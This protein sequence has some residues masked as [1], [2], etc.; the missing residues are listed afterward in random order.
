M[1]KYVLVLLLF[2][3]ALNASSQTGTITGKVTDAKTGEALSFVSVFLANATR[4]TQTDTTGRF[5]LSAIKAG[6]YELVVS[7]I[8][9]NTF[10]KQVTVNGDKQEFQVVLDQKNIQLREIRVGPDP[11]WLRNYEAFKA[12]F[13]GNSPNA[14]QCK[15]LNPRS[16]QVSF[17]NRLLEAYSDEFIVIENKALGYS[18]KYLLNE[19]RRDYTTGMIY[20]EGRVLFEDLPGSKAEKKRWQKNRQDAYYGSAM[21]FL[22]TLKQNSSEDEGFAIRRLVRK[23]NPERPPDSLIKAK[24][25]TF[26]MLS[27]AADGDSA[28]AWSAK[29]GL[30]RIMQFLEKQPVRSAEVARITDKPGTFALTFND[31]LYITYDRKKVPAHNPTPYPLDVAETR[32]VSIVHLTEPYAFFDANGIVINP[33]SLIYEGVW[34]EFVAEM[35]PN[36]YE[37]EPSD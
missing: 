33:R 9:Y 23:P 4:G 34:T 28:R 22:R 20:Y 15:I 13:L 3:Y 21:H 1:K 12:S 37:P 17:E 32:P 27:P 36:D 18:L 24:L 19:F 16:V 6:Q 7:M 2:M 30:P 26:G 11:N 10:S 25:R 5:T 35:L 14:A 8:G 29:S 31:Y